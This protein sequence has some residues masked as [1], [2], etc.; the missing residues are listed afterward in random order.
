MFLA[1][2]LGGI[3]QALTYNY[4]FVFQ[5]KGLVGYQLRFSLV[6]R[7]IMVA[8]LF[9]GIPFGIVGIACASAAGQALM[10]A[11][12]TFIAAPRAGLSRRKLVKIPV[13]AYSMYAVATA[14]G[15]VVSRISD[16]LVAPAQLVLILA[17]FVA[18]AA[19]AIILV[20]RL[21]Q[22]LR[23]VRSTLARA[24]RSKA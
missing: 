6:G 9:A 1:L 23:I 13:A 12:Y 16:S 15:L 14:A 3:F 2:A 17:T 4:M 8:L 5:T 10:W 19:G 20:P 7:S 24:V 21:R 11:L 18:V 22:E